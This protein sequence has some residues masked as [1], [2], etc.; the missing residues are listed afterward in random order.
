MAKKSLTV[1][2]VLAFLLTLC[3]SA[4]S[5]LGSK[6]GSHNPVIGSARPN[7]N[8]DPPLEEEDEEHPWGGAPPNHGDRWYRLHLRAGS[9]DFIILPAFSRPFFEFYLGKLLEEKRIVP[10]E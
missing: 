3:G 10:I 5:V 6:P 7:P 8:L 4:Y 1:V 9:G 2:L